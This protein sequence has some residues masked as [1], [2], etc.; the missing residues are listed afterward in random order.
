MPEDISPDSRLVAR[1][2]IALCLISPSALA[3]QPVGSDPEL[4]S[5]Y[6]VPVLEWQVQKYRQI[7]MNTE[8][9]QQNAPTPELKEQ[10]TSLSADMRKT[11]DSLESA[12][13]R[14]NAYLQSHTQQARSDAR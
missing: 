6:C 1:S 13:K 2:L 5:A 9:W 3:D 7:V 4:R 8:G 11:L 14:V 10:A 12:L